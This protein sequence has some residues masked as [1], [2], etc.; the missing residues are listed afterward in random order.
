MNKI[1]IGNRKYVFRLS[2]YT[3]IEQRLKLYLVISTVTVTIIT[4]TATALGQHQQD[5][6][7]LAAAR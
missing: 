2:G 4:A 7:T 5:S 1:L 6:S 3:V